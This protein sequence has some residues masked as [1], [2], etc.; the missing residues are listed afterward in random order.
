MRKVI[1]CYKCEKKW[2]IKRDYPDQKKNKDDKN[3][4]SSTSMNVLKDNSNDANGDMLSIASN[5]EHLVDFWI[6]DTMCSFHVT[7][8]RDCFDNY[9]LVNFGIVTMSN[10]A[11][12]KITG[13]GNIRI[14]TLDGVVKTLCDVSMYHT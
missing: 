4:G 2:H 1:N 8:N 9:K 10:G 7:S 14:K 6:L 5:S 13:T 12:C 3:V 11:H